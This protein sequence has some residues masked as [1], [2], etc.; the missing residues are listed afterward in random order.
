[1]RYAI[2]PL[3]KE[4]KGGDEQVD[5]ENQNP[6]GK[7]RIYNQLYQEYTDTFQDSRIPRVYIQHQ[8]DEDFSTTV[9]NQQY[10]EENQTSQKDDQYV[11]PVVSRFVGEDNVHNT[12]DW[13]STPSYQ[14][15]TERSGMGITGK[16][17]K[18]G[19][20]LQIILY[21][22]PRIRLVG[23]APR[24][25][26]RTANPKDEANITYNTN[27]RGCV[28]HRMGD[29]L[30]VS[31]GIR[32][33]E[34]R[35][36]KSIHKRSR[37]EDHTIC[38]T[39]SCRKIQK[40]NNTDILGQHNSVEVYNEIR[41][42]F[43]SITPGPS[44]TN[45]RYM[46]HIQHSNHLSTYTRRPQHRSGCTQSQE[47]TFSR[48]SYSKENVPMDRS[49]LG[50]EKS[51]CL[52]SETQPSTNRVLD[53]ESRSQ[54][55]SNRCLPTRLENQEFVSLSSVEV[56]TTSIEEDQR[57]KTKGGSLNNTDVAQPILVSNNSENETSTTSIS[58][59][60]KQKMV[61]SRMEIIHNYRKKVGLD[62]IT[63][64]FLAKKTRE[65]T[66]RMYDNGWNKWGQWCL[67]YD[68]NPEEYNAVNVLQ[69]LRSNIK[70]SNAHLNGLR[71]SIASVFAVIHEDKLPIAE[72]NMIK[73]FFI[74]K[75]KSEV[76]IPAHHQLF[77]WDI[78]ILLR[79]IKE[80]LSSSAEL[81]LQQLQVKTILLLC[82][83][84]MWRPRS[85]IGRLQ[86]QDVHIQAEENSHNITLHS[87]EPKEAQVKS[88][89][90]GE[91]EDKDLYPVHSLIQF[92]NNTN[93]FRQ[94]LP[95]DHSL[96]L[97][98]LAQ[99]DKP[100]DSVRPTTVANWIK[101]EMEKAGI[102]IT[103][104]QAHSIR[105]ASS[106]EAV[107]LGHSRRAV[108]SHAG[109]S[110]LADTFEKYYFKPSSQKSSST[111]INNSIFSSAENSITFSA[112]V[113][114]T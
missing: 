101:D 54:C 3:R 17:S 33:L 27:L 6:F 2:E 84:T 38:P 16:S 104:F 113:T 42:D 94:N 77:T 88:T 55:N 60:S 52:C 24:E 61:P 64:S 44:D 70:Y 68:K 10:F 111:A 31:E 9:K 20:E 36:E 67:I 112:F 73:D 50:K 19:N 35:G 114:S 32:L 13:G 82:M 47:N 93:N 100:S 106:T 12:S 45:S 97:T 41:G 58:V 96:F 7:T 59:A 28:E 4:D 18:L 80:T 37:I 107:E 15:S 23:E 74:A 49:K 46:Q 79:H 98:Y 56:N 90:L 26:K 53:T 71:S 62:D 89:I 66:N 11:L 86:F 43:I 99:T 65:S 83:A 14:V 109:W 8:K 87:R 40:L 63:I 81:S 95:R 21:Q 5:R 102:D 57:T 48:I 108:K 78:T 69:F 110:L 22:H 75:K 30:T 51:R 76:K 34:P 39:T 72:N 103:K 1:M 105:T 85:D 92:L 91:F 29:Q 25:E